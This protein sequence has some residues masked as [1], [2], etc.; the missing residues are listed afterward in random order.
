MTLIKTSKKKT[1]K[2]FGNDNETNIMDILNHFAPNQRQN[3]QNS[4]S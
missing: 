4:F 3:F 1:E 2:I